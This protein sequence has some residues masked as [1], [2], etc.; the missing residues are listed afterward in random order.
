M[1]DAVI[2]VS[3]ALEGEGLPR[4]VAGTT[5]TV[6]ETGVGPVNAAFAL[7]RCLVQSRPRAV[8]ACGVGGAYPGSGLAIG[9]VVSAET[10]TYADLGAGSP[11]GFLDMQALGFPVVDGVPPL[12]NR[13]PLDLFPVHRFTPPPAKLGFTAHGTFCM[14]A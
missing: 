9:E 4:S 5:I 1:S 10:E 13:L 3:T 6:V 2:C 12:F 8:I 11:D 7:T 14:P